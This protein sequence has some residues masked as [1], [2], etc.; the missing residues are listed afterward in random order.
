MK[1]REKDIDAMRIAHKAEIQECKD[2]MREADGQLQ[3]MRKECQQA[4]EKAK[5]V[6]DLN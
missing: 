2:A 1:Q 4:E 5:T 6:S 3:D